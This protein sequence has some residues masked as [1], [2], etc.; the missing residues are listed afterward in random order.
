MTT[1]KIIKLCKHCKV[2]FEATCGRAE[3]CSTAC[4]ISSNVKPNGSCLEWQSGLDKDGY[5]VVK[6]RGGR[7][8][9]AHRASF[10]LVHGQIPSGMMLCHSCDNP[11]CVNPDHLFIGSAKDNKADCV[12]KGRHVKGRGL[13]WKVKLTEQ[14]VLDIRADDRISRL[15]APEYG[16]TKELIQMIRRRAVWKHLA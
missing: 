4:H 8:L 13:Y 11:R 10:E 1:G 16:V 2:G 14:Q 12:S 7:R 6:L 15:V 9:K 5:G 3:Y